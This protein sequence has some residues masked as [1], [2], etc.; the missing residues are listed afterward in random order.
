MTRA[1]GPLHAA[2]RAQAEGMHAC[3]A[4][5]ELLIGHGSWLHRAD[6]VDLFIHTDTG[7]SDGIV[8]SAI[9]WPEALTALD[10]GR[11]PCSGGEGHILRIAASLADG[12]P[13]DLRDALSGLDLTN[14]NLVAAAV[15]H[16]NGKK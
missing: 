4:A 7:P 14:I 13:V 6:F 15:F 11:L 3:E 9:D 12:V 2:L 1:P 8:V 16:A 10:A 5:T